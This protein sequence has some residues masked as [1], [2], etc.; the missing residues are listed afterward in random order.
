MKKATLFLLYL[1]IGTMAIA[2]AGNH[3][4]LAHY[5]IAD[6]ITSR[7]INCISQDESGFIWIG[8]ETG[9]DRFDGF[10]FKHYDIADGKTVFSIYAGKRGELWLGTGKGIFIFNTE[11]GQSKKFETET[12]WGV[13][14]CSKT[15]VIDNVCNKVFIGTGGQGFFLYDP[16]TETL[17]QFCRYASMISAITV[18]RDSLI[19]VGSEE[20][21]ISEFKADGD[22]VRTIAFSP[23]DS[24][25]RMSNVQSLHASGNEL[26]VILQNKGLCRIPLDRL[27]TFENFNLNESRQLHDAKLSISDSDNSLLIGCQNEIKRYNIT[28]KETET[29]IPDMSASPRCLFKDRDGGLW[30]GVEDDGITYC[31]LRQNSF[32]HYFLE[33]NIASITKDNDGNIWAGAVSGTI[34]RIDANGRASGFDL[35]KV[36]NIQCLMADHHKIWIGTRYDG[37]FIHNLENGKTANYRYDRY[38]EFSI[39]DNCVNALF[40]DSTGKIYVGTE[41]GLSYYSADTDGF[42]PEPR[43][44]NHSS[45]VGFFEDSEKNIWILSG[46]DGLYRETLDG[47]IWREFNTSRNKNLTSNT[48]HD[49][50]EDNDGLIWIA[51][52]NGLVTYSYETNTFSPVNRDL[53]SGDINSLEIDSS[54]RIWYVKESALTCISNLHRRVF[55]RES[56]LHNNAFLNGCS[57]ISDNGTLFFGGINGI[58]TFFPDSVLNDSANNSYSPILITDVVVDGIS[59][60]VPEKLT[61]NNDTKRISILFSN[62]SFN[63]SDAD[64]YS[65]HM[66][67]EDTEWHHDNSMA[68]YGHLSPGLHTFTVR[69]KS[70]YGDTEDTINI[71]VM[72]PLYARWWAILIYFS[73]FGLS[74]LTIIN[75]YRRKREESTFR[76]KYNFFTNIIHEIRT[77]LTLIKTP[78]ERIKGTPGLNEQLKGS[79]DIISKGTDSLINLVN[80]LLDYR[81]SESGYYVLNLRPCLVGTLANEI[82]GRFKPI[83]DSEGKALD[84][85]IPSEA[86]SYRVD[87][88]ALEKILNNIL[89]NAVKYAVSSI[90]LKLEE[91]PDYFSIIISNDGEKIAS[92][93]QDNVFKMF[94]Q[95]NGSKNGTGIGLPL[96]RMLAERHGGSITIDPESDMTTFVVKIPGERSLAQ[97]TGKESSGSTPTPISIE[98]TSILVIDDNEDLRR[99]IAEMLKSSYNVIQAGNGKEGVNILEK[100]PVDLILSDIMM[101]EMDGYEFC[102]FLKTDPRYSNI[103]IILITA[104]ASVEDK[105]KGLKYGADDY[106]EKP[107]SPDL[108]VTKV[109]SIISNR[110]KIKEFY[111]GLPIVHPS[112]ISKITKSDSD[113]MNK[114]KEEL[115]K[116]LSDVDYSL[117]NLTEDMF[118]SQS[119]FYRKVKTLTGVSPND[120]VKEFKLQ[121]AAEM[122]SDGKYLASEVYKEVGFN[123]LAY[124]SLCFKKKYGVSPTKYVGSLTKHEEA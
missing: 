43:A 21:T 60:G 25:V 68:T 51:T 42:I 106:I 115:E 104:K 26:W 2:S 89:S 123:S 16:K 98:E 122:L 11:T 41:W 44:S 97:E 88:D 93:E 35:P 71:K 79:L 108:L 87:H 107:F 18:Y 9:L 116:H 77:P 17:K 81:K 91:E 28:S 15:T 111:R 12:E 63:S 56:G 65:F 114:M 113:F 120:F 62:L 37:L 94:Y 22:F 73:I 49:M 90:Y 1:V 100:E 58:D 3:P 55:G 45:V 59:M 10:H 38:N 4:Y 95:V 64:D 19:Y 99:M 72:H 76:E 102:E 103:P 84:I 119:S 48:I 105:I 33:K 57:S 40:K 8:S 117:V 92:T 53:A 31:P 5:R 80:Q 118:M 61:V 52:G 23:E 75:Y 124:F 70:S 39:S 121:R 47:K 50:I 46:N 82:C 66:K 78:L 13:S 32:E 112:K 69:Y 101:P 30:I 110:Q 24:D 83:A 6:G 54:G 14:V 109:R 74:T 85:T 7:F 34:F 36:S 20:S 86:Y 29:I 96:A 27:S 67:G